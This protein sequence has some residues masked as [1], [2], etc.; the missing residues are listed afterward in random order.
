MISA[1]GGAPVPSA[2]RENVLPPM[3]M[4]NDKKRF[5]HRGLLGNAQDAFGWFVAHT[6]VIYF[7]RQTVST[8]SVGQK[9]AI[10]ARPVDLPQR[11]LAGA[12]FR[13]TVDFS[14]PTAATPKVQP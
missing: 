6:E 12:G 2:T 7:V 9:M 14:G 5:V 10:A 3:D 8:P 4:L 1:H 11:F 13:L